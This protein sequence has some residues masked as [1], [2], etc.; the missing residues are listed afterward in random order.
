MEKYQKG[1]IGSIERLDD[2]RGWVRVKTNKDAREVMFGP[3][4]ISLIVVINQKYCF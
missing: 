3:D 1:K 4:D 2:I